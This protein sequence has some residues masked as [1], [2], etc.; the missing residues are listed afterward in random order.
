MTLSFLEEIRLLEANPLELWND[1][2]ELLDCRKNLIVLAHHGQICFINAIGLR[3][4]GYANKEELLGANVLDIFAHDYGELVDMG[5]EVLA[6]EQM[7]PVKMVRQDRTELD[8]EMW[9][10]PLGAPAE[11]IFVV[12]A[13]DIT[14]H[15]RSARALRSREQWL[16][17]IINTV[18]DGIV[19][20]DHSGIVQSF[21]P[22]A[23]RIFGF[24]ASEIIGKN[25]RE[26]VPT[27]IAD[28]V[29]T[30]LGVEW[31]RLATMGEGLFGKRKSGDTFPM[32]I[33][34][35][36][37]FHGDRVSYTGVV[38]DITARR[39]AEAKIRH[40]A[41]HDPLT[42][43]PNRFLFGDR[44]EAAIKRAERHDGRLAVVFID[45]NE[46]KPINDTHGHKVGDQVL[47]T[48][49]E[50]LQSCLRKSDTVARLGGDEFVAI[51]E[52]I[53]SCEQMRPLL[54]KVSEAVNAP[55]VVDGITLQVTVSLGVAVY[56]D[57]SAEPERLVECADKA[58]YLAKQEGQ[59]FICRYPDQLWRKEA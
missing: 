47:T 4:L 58:M 8:V 56:P 53:A 59:S 52:E 38:R 40:M 3:W 39:R 45:V 9:V 49:A 41:Q 11:E 37:L 15:L 35:R 22:A 25:I 46:F 57:D 24:K 7:I 50:R 1:R 44:L 20:V 54:D 18:A 12:E 42:K 32:E 16:E 27:P 48:V 34:M 17:G 21:N 31:H 28:E 33:S 19:T 23:E 55:L 43:L 10:E 13:R 51:L 2:L 29:S 5:L 6:E 36:E 14:E 30:E 26:L